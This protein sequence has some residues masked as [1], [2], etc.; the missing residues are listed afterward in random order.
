RMH[1]LRPWPRRGDWPEAARALAAV[2]R[3]VRVLLLVP[4]L[5]QIQWVVERRVASVASADAV[6]ALDY[7]RFLADTA[8]LPL[9]MPLGVAGLGALASVDETRFRALAERALRVLLYAGVP[10]SVVTALHG[11]AIVRLVFAR[12][13]FG[14]D[15]VAATATILQWAAVGLWAKLLGYAG[16]K[17][18]SARN[19]NVRA[20]AVY[21]A[22][23]L[24]SVAANL[25]LEPLL[26]PAAL[27]VAA[28]AYSLV[29]GFLIVR[30]L[31]LLERLARDVAT[32]GALAAAYTALWALAPT[33]FGVADWLGLA[34]FA[35]YWCAATVSV[36][37]C[38]R[39]L[40]DAWLSFRAA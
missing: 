15:S 29:F 22:A 7:A 21:G 25:A 40:H 35:A 26:G 10:L 31:G 17:F 4:V 1:G 5:L 30:A 14:A 20:I 32:V 18:L 8:V 28:A 12:G 19:R 38:R 6:A 37:R 11:E 36:P 9:A 13:A 27:G 39:V 33:G 2:W 24:C 16:V 3:A 34:A 23:V